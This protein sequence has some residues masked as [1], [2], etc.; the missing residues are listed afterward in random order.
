MYP[1]S[2]FIARWRSWWVVHR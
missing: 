2:S 1:L